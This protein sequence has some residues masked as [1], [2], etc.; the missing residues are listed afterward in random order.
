MLYDECKNIE[1]LNWYRYIWNS[2]FILRFDKDIMS[3]REFITFASTTLA[4]LFSLLFSSAFFYNTFEENAR[5]FFYKYC[6]KNWITLGTLYE[7]FFNFQLTASP[8]SNVCLWLATT[9]AVRT[10]S[11][12]TWRRTWWSLSPPAWGAGRAEMDFSLPLIVSRLLEFMV[13]SLLSL[14]YRFWLRKVRSV[15]QLWSFTVSD[16]SMK[17]SIV[18]EAFVNLYWLKMTMNSE[19]LKS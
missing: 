19:S 15:S 3:R 10:S 9:L 8:V 13:R 1:I 12:T 7:P 5:H 11:T 14:S 2:L 16:H 6:T 18:W 4:C 17:K